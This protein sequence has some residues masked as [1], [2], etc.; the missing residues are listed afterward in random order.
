MV[1][2]GGH[3]Q[4][5]KADPLFRPTCGNYSGHPSRG[6]RVQS[7]CLPMLYLLHPSAGRPTSASV[8]VASITAEPP[9]EENK[10]VVKIDNHSV[11]LT[12]MRRGVFVRIY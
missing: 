11:H 7:S 6:G 9:S 12:L 1:S 3:L 10:M 8:I 2:L 4:T 5:A